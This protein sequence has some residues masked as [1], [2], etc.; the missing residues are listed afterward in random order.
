MT[1]HNSPFVLM[2]DDDDDD[3]MLAKDAFA[4]SG[5]KGDFICVEN[6]IEL[7]ESLSVG[8]IPVFILLDL[9][10]PRKDGRQVLKEIKG[11]P[12]FK[13]I[14]IVVL[15][16]SSEEKDIQY[17]RQMGAHSFMTKPA[18]FGEWVGMM[19]TLAEELINVD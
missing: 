5:A 7:L 19:K 13:S 14:P 12:E 6:G 17:S 11:M 4:A 16:T 15:T 1:T 18:T 8:T 10:M 9:N 2:A 3:C